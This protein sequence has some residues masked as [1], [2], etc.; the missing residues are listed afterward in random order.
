MA[1]RFH[2][3]N[4]AYATARLFRLASP[5]G[6]TLYYRDSKVKKFK[7]SRFYSHSGASEADLLWREDR[8]VAEDNQVIR[9]PPRLSPL[10]AA[11]HV[12]GVRL[13]SGH[14]LTLP[15]PSALAR[16]QRDLPSTFATDVRTYWVRAAAGLI[17]FGL[18]RV[19]GLHCVLHWVGAACL[20]GVL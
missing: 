16:E 13:T 12:K 11:L 8:Q 10:A 15:P 9:Q 7:S 3:A 14:P 1:H 20:A 5:I 6:G 17:E 2:A 18:G 19:P 4:S